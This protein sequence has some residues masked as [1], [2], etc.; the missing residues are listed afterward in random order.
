VA[1][2]LLAQHGQRGA[3]DVGDAEEV[4]LDLRAKVVVGHVLD[5]ADVAVPGVVDHDV[6]TAESLDGLLHGRACRSR[7]GHVERDRA[8]AIAVLRDQC[9]QVV[10]PTRGGDDAG[11]AA[12]TALASALPRPRELPVMSQVLNVEVGMGASLKGD[13]C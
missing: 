3:R 13:G 8:N 4:G 5:G 9:R 6:E 7:I 2:A 11:P 1:A 10:R 12:R